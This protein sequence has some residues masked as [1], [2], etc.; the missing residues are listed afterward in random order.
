ML[1]KSQMLIERTLSFFKAPRGGVSQQPEAMGKGIMLNFDEVGANYYNYV[2]GSYTL[3]QKRQRMNEY[4][5]MEY[6]PEVADAI[7][8][9]VDS[10]VQLNIEDTAVHL[11]IT[12]ENVR[13]AKDGEIEILIQE[14]WEYF[15]N[16]VYGGND[17]L[18]S[19]FRRWFVDGELYLEN[20]KGKLGEGY[21]KIKRLPADTMIMERNDI[22]AIIKYWQILS[23]FANN[24]RPAGGYGLPASNV[25]HTT[26]MSQAERIEFKLDEITYCDSGLYGPGGLIDSRSRLEYALRTYRQIKLLEDA[27]VI[28]R[29]VRAPEKRVFKI[30][31]GNMPKGAAESYMKELIERYRT[32]KIYDPSTGQ[33]NQKYNP[34]AMTEDYWIPHRGAG[35]GDTNI[36]VLKGGEHLGEISDVEYF[37]KKLYRS[38]KVPTYMIE[39]KQS[40]MGDKGAAVV[41]QEDI[42]FARHIERLQ[43]QFAE[44]LQKLFVNHLIL[45]KLDKLF[46]DMPPRAIQLKF[47]PPSY[48][49]EYKDI[50]VAAARVAL[51]TQMIETGAYPRMYLLKNIMKMTDVEIDQL[52]RDMLQETI[53]D[54]LDQQRLE[55]ALAGATKVAGDNQK[56]K[57]NIK[58]KKDN[59]TDPKKTKNFT[60]QT[61]QKQTA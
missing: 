52:K 56:A 10:A 33:I 14:E 48:Y 17:A 45:R 53:F 1:T 49:K 30:N 34:I 11:E 54:I 18:D 16:E 59:A 42:R 21:L 28:Y 15:F 2:Y 25:S 55:L 50:E 40:P 4:R 44:H 36:D 9:V 58:V 35:V 46:D 24:P 23:D 32:K 41:T 6:Y 51:F 8:L 27:L 22:G 31:I 13:L 26:P 39:N 47:T 3:Q 19:N 7:D 60:K 38:L 61:T 12:D 57:P 29:I 37:L 20:V 43:N 5:E